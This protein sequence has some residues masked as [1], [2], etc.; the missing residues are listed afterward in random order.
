M[1]KK[2]EDFSLRDAMNMANSPA[3]KQLL[4]LLKSM[5]AAALQKAMDE[6]A[7]GNF[8]K[9]RESLTPFLED[10]KAKSLLKQMGGNVE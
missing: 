2:S 7:A 8:T 3:G 9:V 1:Q 6:A 10:E 4:N 5:D